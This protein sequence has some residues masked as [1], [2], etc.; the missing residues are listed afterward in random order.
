MQGTFKKFF[1][2]HQ[3]RLARRLVRLEAKLHQ[4]ETRLGHLLNGRLSVAAITM[5]I[6]LVIASGPE[7]R[8]WGV[9]FLL[10]LVVFAFLVAKTR[11]I[12]LSQR[13]M[14]TWKTH[15]LRQ[16]TRLS[17]KVNHLQAA[18]NPLP[19]LTPE[20]EILARDLHLLGQ[21]SLLTLVDETFT[22]GGFQRL[23]RLLVTPLTTEAQIRERQQLLKRL[24]ANHWPVTRFLLLGQSGETQPNTRLLITELERPLTAPGFATLAVLHLIVYPLLVA[25]IVAWLSG[26]PWLPPQLALGIYFLFSLASLGKAA[27][28]FSQGEALSHYLEA[29]L[30][31]YE[32]FER[33]PQL[34]QELAP[35]TGR[36]KP[37][38]Q[39]RWLNFLLSCLSVQAH[40]LVFLV[41]NTV[42]PWTYLWAGLLERWRKKN[43]AEWKHSLEEIEQ[44]EAL[45]SLALLHT[46][47]SPHFPEFQ[48]ANKIEAQGL[49]HPLIHRE[50]VVANDFI[51]A[52]PRSLVL[53]TGSNMSG[54]STFLRTLGLNQ[55]LAM[56]GAPVFASHF[57]TYFAPV[58]T[59]LQIRDSLEDGY[60]SFYYEVKRVRLVLGQAASHQPLI[61]LIDE[62]FRGTNN[63]E[64]LIG[65]QA[66]IRALLKSTRAVGLISTHDLELTHLERDFP[67]LLN[68]HF[69]DE[70]RAAAPELHFT[71][72]YH[73]GPCPTTNAL[74]LMAAEGLPVSVDPGT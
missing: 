72:R 33:H 7:Y 51:L 22:T 50:Q 41:I 5:V 49:F 4:N 23:V 64:R 16:M 27:K 57:K 66:V 25:T 48:S 20:E 73:L 35:V 2:S 55:H 53:I 30:P 54:K 63:R 38:K 17:G 37:L 14:Q 44:F 29:L 36:L 12:R 31:V 32:W 39:L 1:D 67:Q 10:G 34:T 13:R 40:P 43:F 19:P 26:H 65:S 68:G 9:A 6:G 59:C 60:S 69:R 15:L 62:I 24:S 3:Q 71:Y 58:L 45:G 8:Q 46:Y 56:I 52:P 47:Q 42:F 70:V 18:K 61:Y 28:G 21:N 74:K 11:K